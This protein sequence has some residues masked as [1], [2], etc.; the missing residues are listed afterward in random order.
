MSAPRSS[1]KRSPANRKTRAAMRAVSKQKTAH[2]YAH[3]LPK[4]LRAK[5][6]GAFDRLS[7]VRPSG[8]YRGHSAWDPQQPNE[9]I[10]RAVLRAND[11]DA[12]VFRNDDI[13][14]RDHV[15][16]NEVGRRAARE[17]V[18]FLRTAP[19]DEADGSLSD[20]VRDML[21]WPTSDSSR[22][23]EAIGFFYELEELL[24]PLIR[25]RASKRLSA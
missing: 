21:G 15:I 5:P 8:S 22:R 1:N 25:R 19:I 4:P 12:S 20:I 24:R 2:P 17:Y 10:L 9:A 18:A 3:L 11:N 13:P 6:L 14:T 23:G 7:F 16:G